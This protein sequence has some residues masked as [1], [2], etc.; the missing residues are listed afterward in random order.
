MTTPENCLKIL[1]KTDQPGPKGNGEITVEIY[2]D[3]TACEGQ[4]VPEGTPCWWTGFDKLT[5]VFYGK[6]KSENES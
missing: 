5:G 2:A 4:S 3:G 6:P 1:N